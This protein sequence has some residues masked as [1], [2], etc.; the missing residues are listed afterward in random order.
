MRL[1]DQAGR[2]L[3]AGVL[4]TAGMT[5]WQHLS[6]RLASSGE[7]EAPSQDPWEDAPVP[8]KVARLF[9]RRALR[10]DPPADAIP[11]LTQAMHWSYGTSWG[12]VYGVAA[13]SSPR[14]RAL[15]R[16]ALFGTFVWAMSYAQLVPMGLYEPPWT[17]PPAELALDLSHHLVYGVGTALSLQ[18]LGE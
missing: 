18:A 9:I 10:R 6:A 16:G 11:L 5:S 12:A 3:A 4:G 7:D 8:A 2:G 17:Y 15:S 1:R 14:R 13:G